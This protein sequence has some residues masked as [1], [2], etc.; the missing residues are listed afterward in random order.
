MKGKPQSIC[1]HDAP[2]EPVS[3]PNWKLATLELE[4]LPHWQHS[5]SPPLRA[6]SLIRIC[7]VAGRQGKRYRFGGRDFVWGGFEGCRGKGAHFRA[8]LGVGS[9]IPAFARCCFCIAASLLVFT[10]PMTSPLALLHQSY[11]VNGGPPLSGVNW[12]GGGGDSSRATCE[13]LPGWRRPDGRWSRQSLLH[14]PAES[15]ST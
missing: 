14:L 11:C 9:F 6:T 5:Q 2:H 1:Q 10:S 12:H 15:F 4:T 13:P 8:G 3:I 7:D